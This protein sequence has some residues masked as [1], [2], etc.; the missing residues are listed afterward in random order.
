MELLSPG[1]LGDADSLDKAFSGDTLNVLAMASR[2]GTS[3]G[4]ITRVSDDPIGDFLLESWRGLGID[5]SAALQVRGFNAFEFSS[6][7]PIGKGQRVHYRVGSVASTLVTEDLDVGYIGGAKILHV[8]AISQGISATCREAVFEAVSIARSHGVLV[9]YDTNLRPQLW[10]IEEARKALEEILPHV[11]II[12]PSHPQE[13]KALIGLDAETEV[14]D[15][16]LACGVEVVALKCGQDGAWVGTR[17]GVARVPAVAPLGV[18]D[19]VGAGDTFAGAF[20]HCIA[21]GLD[22]FESARWG[23]ASAGLKVG[24][25]SIVAQ[26]AREQV[27]RCLESVRVHRL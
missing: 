7:W 15:H 23:V 22:P 16:F 4:Y 27:E 11:D 17:S 10:A 5:T 19:P 6:P 3:C 13:P 9:S 18:L 1:P 25:R 8:S 2:L 21:Q 20:L 12:F 24:G 14:I 26:P